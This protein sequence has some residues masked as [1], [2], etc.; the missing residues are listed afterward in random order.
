M[1]VSCRTLRLLEI[2]EYMKLIVTS[3]AAGSLLA[4]LAIAQTP[5]YIITDL[6][7]LGTGTFDY[8]THITNSSLVSGHTTPTYGPYHAVLWQKGRITDIGTPGLDGPNSI[9]WS[10]NERGQAVGQAET[11]TSDPNGEDFCGSTALGLPFF[12]STCLPFLWQNG[13]MTPLHPLPGG[14]NGVANAINNGGEAAGSAENGVTDPTCPAGPQ[15]F[16][17][18][19]VIWAANGKVQE[20]PMLHGD[21]DGLAFGINDYGQVV[22]ASGICT[23]FDVIG[24]TYLF[25]LHALLWEKGGSVHDLGTLGGAIGN[26]ANAVNNLSQVVGSSGLPGDT[27]FHAFL[28]TRATGMQDLLPLP[29]DGAHPADAF[30]VALHINDRGEGADRQSK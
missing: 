17:F 15:K 14:H 13:V 8:A 19:P 12:G 26:S 29:A 20:L 18:K 28:W 22:G 10:V 16:Q 3:I 7:A 24:K 6:G 21:P 5:R 9:A 27:T 11:S 30:S 1:R 25:P 23:T 4:A 2:E